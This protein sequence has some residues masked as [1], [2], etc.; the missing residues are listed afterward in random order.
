MPVAIR[1]ITRIA[2]ADDANVSL[3]AGVDEYALVYDHDTAKFVLRAPAA[4]FAGILATGA[5][6]GA[7]SQAQNFTVGVTVG[8]VTT[9]ATLLQVA[10]TSTASPR[11]IMSSQHSTGVDGARLHMRKS[12]GTN[13]TPTVITTGD[14]LGRLVASGYD[15]SNYLEMGGIDIVSAGTIASTRV[16]TEIRFLTATDA[17]PSVLTQRMVIDKAGNVGIGTAAPLRTLHV[18]YPTPEI[19][20]SQIYVEGNQGGW[21]AGISFASKLNYSPNTVTAQAKI[22]A[23]GTGNWGSAGQVSS[24]LTFWTVNANSLTEKMVIN[25]AGDIGI[26]TASPAT[27]LHAVSTT[28]TTNAIRNVLMLGS[29]VT[30]AGVGAAGLGA[31]VLFTMETT[32]TV[33]TS[34]ASVQ[35]IIYEATHATRKFDLVGNAYDTAIREG[36]R[37]RG[38]GSAPA[39]GFLGA[40][41]QARIAHVADASVAYAAGDLDTEAEVIAALNAT[42]GKINSILATLELFGFHA[43][44]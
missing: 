19:G 22:V 33:D 35:A 29:N 28:A 4:P 44:S 14:V 42:N 5:T 3:G 32:T 6:V 25:A 15:G 34:A 31:A 27:I 18:Y 17:A 9:A 12:R 24:K 39:I 11:G 1:A 37:V 43:T 38:N 20:Y 26:G 13:A 8:S 21:G 16:P 30:G 2:D 23:D 41:P 36:W 40:T 7:T 10:E